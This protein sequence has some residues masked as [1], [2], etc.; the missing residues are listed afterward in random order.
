MQ[1]SISAGALP[2][3]PLGKLTA[4]LCWWSLQRSPGP[5]AAFKGP[6]FQGRGEEGTVNEGEKE[7]RLEFGPPIFTTDRRHQSTRRR[8]FSIG[9]LSDTNPS[10]VAYFPRFKVADKTDTPTDI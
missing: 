6:Y 3:T 8:H 1:N 10:L 9:S 2:Q 7:G 5:L 4:L